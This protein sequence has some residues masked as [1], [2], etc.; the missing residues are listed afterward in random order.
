MGL[1]ASQEEEHIEHDISWSSSAVRLKGKVF[2]GKKRVGY[3]MKEELAELKESLHQKRAVCLTSQE[4]KT[5]T[6]LFHKNMDRMTKTLDKMAFLRLFMRT[7]DEGMFDAAH[8]DDAKH[9]KSGKYKYKHKKN[10]HGKVEQVFELFMNCDV[11]GNGKVDLEEFLA[12]VSFWKQNADLSPEGRLMLYF[13]LFDSKNTGRLERADFHKLLCHMLT[14]NPHG[15]YEKD[16]VEKFSKSLFDS[17]EKRDEDK[18]IKLKEFQ[19]WCETNPEAGIE[20]DAVEDIFNQYDTDGNKRI[21]LIEFQFL[22]KQRH[23]QTNT[24]EKGPV[25][26]RLDKITTKVW[27]AV[28]IDNSGTIEFGEFQ[29]WLMQDASCGTVQNLCDVMK[30]VG[31]DLKQL[32]N[33]AKEAIDSII[34]AAGKGP[35]EEDIKKQVKEEARQQKKNDAKQAKKDAKKLKKE[36]EKEKKAMKKKEKEDAE[37]KKEDE[38]AHKKKPSYKVAAAANPFGRKHSELNSPRK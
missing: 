36:E 25:K 16:M 27:K 9:D 37:K 26:A 11:D 13:N 19:K 35:T 22:V 23:M 33:N 17:I 28:D 14:L 38:E 20:P 18:G 21:T 15:E 30:D 32:N 2:E 29:E 8:N 6:E 3:L 10:A 4:T 7:G 24:F 31:K 1:C 12:G 34:N 5:L